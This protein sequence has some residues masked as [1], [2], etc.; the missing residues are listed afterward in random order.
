LTSQRLEETHRFFKNLGSN[1]INSMMGYINLTTIIDRIICN[2][3]YGASNFGDIRDL[4]TKMLDQCAYEQIL[5]SKTANLVSQDVYNKMA[6]YKKYSG[7]SFSA[8]SNYCHICSKELEPGQCKNTSIRSNNS[9][10]DPLP[11]DLSNKSDL[12]ISFEVQTETSD[13]SVK[14]FHCGHSFHESCLEINENFDWTHLGCPVCNMKGIAAKKMTKLPS[15]R[16]TS[17]PI[18]SPTKQKSPELK[19]TSQTNCYSSSN[20]DIS[21]SPRQ[22]SALKSIRSRK[23][24]SFISNDQPLNSQRLLVQPSN[25]QRLSKLTLAPG[26]LCKFIQS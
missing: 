4:M 7:K 25:I 5:L 19:K 13:V 16:T 15:P 8:Q 17:S 14:L 23:G 24:G 10:V 12:Q 18:K 2:P 3:M 21:F 26:N 9:D 1:L 6:T 20:R 22:V 11:L